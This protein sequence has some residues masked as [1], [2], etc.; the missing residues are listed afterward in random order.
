MSKAPVPR[1]HNTTGCQ[2]RVTELCS[3]PS[4]HNMPVTFN[5]MTL[6]MNYEVIIMYWVL[7]CDLKSL[8]FWDKLYGQVEM[9]H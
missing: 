6:L 3:L 9:Y 7:R 4:A 1:L 8:V 2:R 5:Y